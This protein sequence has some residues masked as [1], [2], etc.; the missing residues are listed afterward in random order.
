MR[1]NPKLLTREKGE[2]KTVANLTQ[3]P[4]NIKTEL[5]G[6]ASARVVIGLIFLPDKVR[7][8]VTLS[9]IIVMNTGL[10]CAVTNAQNG[11]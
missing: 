10:I 2:T 9:T 3:T 5:C 1:Q 7:L 8:I 6:V 4:K 11:S